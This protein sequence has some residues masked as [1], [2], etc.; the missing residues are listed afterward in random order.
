MFAPF[1]SPG[2]VSQAGSGWGREEIEQA[3]ER[4]DVYIMY[5]IL[6]LFYCAL[7]C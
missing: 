4:G 5:H 6:Q 3:V 2:R 1:G 7:G